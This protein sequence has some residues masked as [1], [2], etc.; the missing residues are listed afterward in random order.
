MIQHDF[1]NS[2]TETVLQDIQYLTN[3]YYY[4]IGRPYAWGIS[5][6]PPTT[7][8]LSQ[9]TVN[10]TRTDSLYFKKIQPSDVSVVCNRYNWTSGTVYDMFDHTEDMY[11]KLFYVVV[12]DSI[13][14]K[15]NVYKCLNNNLDSASTQSPSG[16]SPYAQTYSDGY[17]WKFMYSITESMMNAFGTATKIPVQVSMTSHFY[18]KGS[19]S[20]LSIIDGGSG[21]PSDAVIYISGDGEGANATPIITDGVITGI[22]MNSN[23]QGY[24]YATITT[25]VSGGTTASIK[26]VIATSAYNTEQA[27]VEQLAVSGGIHAVHVT[28]GGTFYSSGTTVSI[29]GDGINAAATLTIIDGVITRINMTSIGQNY[30]YANITITDPLQ[31]ERP[32]T[33][34]DFVGYA[35]IPPNGGH[36]KNAIK[37]L[38]GEEIIVNSSIPLMPFTSSNDFRQFGIIKNPTYIASGKYVKLIN[39]LVAYKVVLNTTNQL[40]IDSILTSNSST[41][42][43]STYRVIYFDTN[44]KEVLLQPL[45]K[46]SYATPS[47][48]IGLQS[49]IVQSVVTSPS[50]DKYS[51]DLLYVSNH[52]PFATVVDQNI[53]LKTRIK[54]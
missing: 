44:T 36:G 15:Y 25:S 10:Q 6:T 38:F 47:S 50:I 24:T 16:T 41:D 34:T 51:G 22:Q 49:Y 28:S 39:E 54:F 52:T 37:E 23:G 3:N 43:T 32:S 9:E 45:S 33:A 14:S 4:F 29:S 26:A 13:Y 20:G 19:I 5:D 7:Q 1:H 8:N 21:Y 27:V 2:L 31:A 46:N 11:G 40:S 17:V 35:I 30:T 18:N 48:L 12:Y 42:T 53:T